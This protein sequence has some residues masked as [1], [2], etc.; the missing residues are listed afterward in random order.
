M[1]CVGLNSG[2]DS[3]RCI[4]YPAE[5]PFLGRVKRQE[6]KDKTEMKSIVLDGHPAMWLG[7]KE[8]LSVAGD[9]SI[10]GETGEGGEALCLVG[11]ATTDLVTRSQPGGDTDG[12]E[13]CRRLEAVPAPVREVE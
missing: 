2:V 4:P 13:V 3:R 6:G 8:C 9:I 12:V 5:V 11:D 10:E 1:G 7:L